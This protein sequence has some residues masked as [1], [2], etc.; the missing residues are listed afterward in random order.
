MHEIKGKKGANG[1]GKNMN[2]K[3]A[4]DIMRMENQEKKEELK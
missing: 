3:N 4:E 1:M 2:G